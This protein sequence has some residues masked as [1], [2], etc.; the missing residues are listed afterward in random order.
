MVW[1]T[2]VSLWSTTSCGG[3]DVVEHAGQAGECAG[4]VVGTL[5]L[6]GDGFTVHRSPSRGNGMGGID[7]PT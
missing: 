3:I 1:G 6:Q 5:D 4:L 7:T 2:R